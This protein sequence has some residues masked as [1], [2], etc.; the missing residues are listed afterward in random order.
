MRE[1]KFRGMRIDTNSWIYGYIFKT[2][3]SNPIN[4]ETYWIFN[5]DDKF[6]V[7]PESIGELIERKDKS[8]KE[9]YEGDIVKWVN[10][11]GDENFGWIRYSKWIVGF[12]IVLIKGSYISF[13]T[14]SVR[15]F[16]WS[17]LEIIGNRCENPELL[18]EKEEDIFIKELKEK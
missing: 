13:Y 8:G 11:F 7:I 6:K 17:D 14:G 5:D 16:A 15:N 4:G 2:K 1:Y 12:N 18:G 9:M 3:K 10:N